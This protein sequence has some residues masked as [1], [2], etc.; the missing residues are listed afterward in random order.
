MELSTREI[1]LVMSSTLGEV[2]RVKLEV[3]RLRRK[4]Q[5]M[6]DEGRPFFQCVEQ[7]KRTY[8]TLKLIRLLALRDRLRKSLEFVS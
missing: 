4:I 1:E 5:L 6:K 7:R 3:N 8:Y 2:D